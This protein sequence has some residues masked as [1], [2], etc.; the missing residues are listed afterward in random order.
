MIE[1]QLFYYKQP[2]SDNP[3]KSI[4]SFFRSFDAALVSMNADIESFFNG[5]EI[6]VATEY[7]GLEYKKDVNNLA[8]ATFEEFEWSVGRVS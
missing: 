2:C 8:T 6:S 4:T 5:A 1:E 3:A 7:F